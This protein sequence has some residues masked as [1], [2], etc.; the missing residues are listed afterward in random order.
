MD[1]TKT[2][3]YHY[4]KYMWMHLF[5]YAMKDV[6]VVYHSPAG[7][8]KKSEFTLSPNDINFNSEH[9]FDNYINNTESVFWTEKS[10]IEAIEKIL[11]KN[12]FKV[13]YIISTDVAEIIWF[14]VN[15]V[16]TVLNSNYA[17]I[18]FIYL[19][20]QAIWWNMFEWYRE[21]L[22]ETLVN[23]DISKSNIKKE[24]SLNIF[25]YF[26]TRNEG[27]FEWDI[28]EFQKILFDL[29]LELNVFS[30]Y[31]NYDDFSKINLSDKS[32]IFPYADSSFD[33]LETKY[34][35][36]VEFVDFPIWIQ[37]T[38]NFISKIWDLFN[39]ET[40]DYID[41]ELKRIIPRINKIEHIILGKSFW[42]VWDSQRLNTLLDLLL[43]V[44]M[45]PE[46][47]VYLDDFKDSENF[48]Q[49]LK[50]KYNYI[51]NIDIFF[52]IDRNRINEI[53]NDEK[54]CLDLLIWSSIEKY[55]LKNNTAFLEFFFPCITRHFI[56]KYTSVWFNWVLNILNDIYNL[57]NKPEYYNLSNSLWNLMW[58]FSFY[59]A[60][61]EK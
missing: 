6:F 28:E 22:S 34:S 4:A 55:N 27:D 15:Q 37:N 54:Y 21:A 40:T 49:E 20:W 5:C 57:L 52:D 51:A 46:F 61:N 26:F 39:L 1:L 17:D 12:K 29:W 13:I 35:Q 7:C 43:D 53:I 10:L 2:T 44:W 8:K 45:R 33:I 59:Y 38:I 23:L 11:S 18:E 50:N 19:R 41:R 48:M 16:I 42:I 3:N 31:S 56:N 36:K 58:D 14:D 25:G 32:I 47:V 24:K 30:W 60:K 9:Y